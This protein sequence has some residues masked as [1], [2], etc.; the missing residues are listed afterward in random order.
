[1]TLKTSNVKEKNQQKGKEE[2]NEAS[3]AFNTN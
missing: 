3:F 2:S 1:M